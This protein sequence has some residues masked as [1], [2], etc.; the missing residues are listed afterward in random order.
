MSWRR[1]QCVVVLG[2]LLVGATSSSASA[3]GTDDRQVDSALNDIGAFVERYYSRAQSV[4][5]D[6]RVHVRHMGRD[7]TPLG[8]PRRL[9]YEMRVEWAEGTDGGDR[10]PVVMRQLLEADGRPPKPDDDPECT[11]PKLVS[12][13]PLAMFLPSRQ[14]DYLFGGTGRDRTR[15]QI[16]RRRISH[17][18]VGRILYRTRFPRHIFVLCRLA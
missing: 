15:V 16:T 10:E 1:T 3:Q 2:A 6:V 11:D 4:V 7:L 12:D 18:R 14:R 9:L 5:A 17:D 8:R 13:E